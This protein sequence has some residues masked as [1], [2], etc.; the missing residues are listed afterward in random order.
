[1]RV[2]FVC[3]Y[4]VFV[5][6]CI[7]EFLFFCVCVFLCLHVCVCCVICVVLGV[8]RAFVCL[9]ACMCVSLSVRVCCV[10]CCGRL[11][12][13]RVSL[14]DLSVLLWFVFCVFL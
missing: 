1:M 11:F 10:F 12:M 13:V 8:M 2:F 6:A 7:S 4:C 14:C 3:K 5:R 9:C